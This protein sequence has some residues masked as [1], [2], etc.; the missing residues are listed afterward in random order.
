ME[1]DTKA[2]YESDDSTA[3]PG[4]PGG[5]SLT[6]SSAESRQASFRDRTVQIKIAGVFQIIL[7]FLSGLMAVFMLFALFSGFISEA[8]LQGT[9]KSVLIVPALVYLAISIFFTGTGISAILLKRWVRA[10]ML[11]LF[12]PLLVI[13]VHTTVF[14]FFF[15]P[16]ILEQVSGQ[17]GATDQITGCVSCLTYSVLIFVYIVIPGILVG[18]YSG[19]NVRMT[20]EARDPVR[21]WTDACPLPVLGLSLYLIFIGLAMLF[22]RSDA[23][24]LFGHI[25]YGL[26]AKIILLLVACI[27][28]V[29]AW[30]NYRLKIWAWWLTVITWAVFLSST[31]ISM[32][33][34]R[35]QEYSRASGAFDERSLK[36]YEL[37]LASYKPHLIILCFSLL[38]VQIF[39]LVYIKKFYTRAS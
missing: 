35:F 12:V 33:G 3:E 9:S 15:L 10:V 5:A 31:A 20:F 14:M 37:L 2:R 26:W 19:R 8:A 24:P 4:N 29:L 39:Y 28:F 23:Y 34:S 36:L 17:Q 18:L 16:L 25:F 38:I 1:E 30:G 21:R 11:S 7:G 6:H 22:A 32:T 13:G 27:D